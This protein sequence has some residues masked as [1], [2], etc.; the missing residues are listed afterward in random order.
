MESPPGTERKG[1]LCEEQQ[2]MTGILVT[3]WLM[4]P[5]L[6][7]LGLSLL[8]LCST[9]MT[10]VW[11]AL[12]KKPPKTKNQKQ[13]QNNPPQKKPKK[14]PQKQKQTNKQKTTQKTP[15]QPTNNKRKQ[16]KTKKPQPN[17]QQQPLKEVA[18]LM[19]KINKLGKKKLQPPGHC[20]AWLFPEQAC[21]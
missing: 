16:N 5:R 21:F 9:P 12:H 13:K 15:N 4:Q 14:T 18:V 10:G 3:S 8:S 19:V 2:H 6:P 1:S 7:R 17:P 20:L 11:S